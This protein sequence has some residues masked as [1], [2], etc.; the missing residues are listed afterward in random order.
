MARFYH[1]NC[2]QMKSNKSGRTWRKEGYE[3]NNKWGRLQKR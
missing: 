3:R 2:K 1:R